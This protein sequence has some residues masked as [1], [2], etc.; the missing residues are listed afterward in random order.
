MRM[1]G[2]RIWAALALTLLGSCS[3]DATGPG[4]D[5]MTDIEVDSFVGILNNARTSA[6]NADVTA[7]GKLQG[8]IACSFI[9]DIAVVGQYTLNTTGTQVDNDRTF[10]FR[11]CRQGADSTVFVLNGAIREVSKEAYDAATVTYTY[12][13]HLTGTLNWE[14]KDRSG[15]CDVDVALAYKEVNG[16]VTN[17]TVTGKV[18]GQSADSSL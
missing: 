7:D 18:C 13:F 11:K 16:V 2:R 12:D 5:V 3:K 9:G 4:T 1:K 8:V 15:V 6:D 10:T 14:V 17:Q